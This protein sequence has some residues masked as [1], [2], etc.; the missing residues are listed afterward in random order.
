M[1][2]AENATASNQPL[3]NDQQVA[4][5][6]L[7]IAQSPDATEKTKQALI[8]LIRQTNNL[9]RS[10]AASFRPEQNG[11]EIGCGAH[12]MVS[13]GCTTHLSQRLG[14]TGT[15][16]HVSHHAGRYM[17]GIFQSQTY[18]GSYTVWVSREGK[19]YDRNA[20]VLLPDMEAIEKICLDTREITDRLWKERKGPTQ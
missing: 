3:L 6:E 18:D 19:F 2:D 15:P 5:I 16:M 12:Q 13:D 17:E 7:L 10:V 11:T 20:E 4:A 1:A 9:A 8:W 14:L